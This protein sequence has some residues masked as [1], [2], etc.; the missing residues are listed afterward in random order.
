MVRVKGEVVGLPTGAAATPVFF[1][2]TAVTFD[3]ASST[4]QF[5]QTPILCGQVLAGQ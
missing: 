1:D 3:P 4:F 5:A 2:G